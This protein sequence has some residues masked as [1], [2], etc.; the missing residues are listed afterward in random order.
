MVI[1]CFRSADYNKPFCK[2]I[3]LKKKASPRPPPLEGEEE[4][5]IEGNS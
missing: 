4:N 1:H 5:T 2:N 3:K